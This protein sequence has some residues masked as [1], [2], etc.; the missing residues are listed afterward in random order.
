MWVL[1]FACAGGECT[2]Q[3]AAAAAE[4]TSTITATTTTTTTTTATATAAPHT[5]V[6][7]MKSSLPPPPHMLNIGL[8][9][10][11]APEG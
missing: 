6:G 3:Q 11:I 10:A 9:P 4:A 1:G 5:H 8:S 2:E 7:S